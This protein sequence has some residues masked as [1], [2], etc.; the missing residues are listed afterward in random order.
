[1]FSNS[2]AEDAFALLS[3][4]ESEFFFI[5]CPPWGETRKCPLSNTFCQFRLIIL[6]SRR[7]SNKTT[8]LRT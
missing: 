2:A 4:D 5:H 1:M 7:A 3:D 6:Q 8:A